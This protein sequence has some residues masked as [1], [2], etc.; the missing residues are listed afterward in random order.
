MKKKITDAGADRE[1]P[2]SKPEEV[3]RP[4]NVVVPDLLSSDEVLSDKFENASDDITPID[5]V[6]LGSR[7]I[8]N[9]DLMRM[10][11]PDYA[12]EIEKPSLEMTSES[13]TEDFEEYIPEEIP[14]PIALQQHDSPSSEQDLY[15]PDIQDYS[16]VRVASSDTVYE[17]RVRKLSWLKPRHVLIPVT[18]IAIVV[19]FLSVI[20]VGHLN[21]RL[22]SP[23]MIHG[24]TVSNPSF[25]FM[26]NFVLMENGVDILDAS[27]KDM[28]KSPGDNGF[29]TNREYFLDMTA[30]EMQ[31]TAI[32]YD[33]AISKGYQIEA[34]HVERAQAYLDWLGTKAQS[35][36]VDLNTYIKGSYG[37]TVTQELIIE[38]LSRRYFAE[39]YA[40]GHK[41]DELKAT[42]EQAEEAYALTPN[43]YDLISYRVLR[44]VFEQKED[45]FIA[46]AHLR[47]Q[48]II[49]G[50]GHDQS[51]F[52]TVAAEY[53]SGAEKDKLLVPDSTLIP[54]VRYNEVDDIEWRVWL[55]DPARQP[56]DCTIFDDEY[57]FPIL[58][59]FSA[60]VRQ[61][62][63]LR[64]IRFFYINRE[65]ATSGTAGVSNPEILPLAQTI[66]DSVTNEISMMNLETTYADDLLS[67]V[68]TSSQSSD[69]F[70]GKYDAAFEEWIF[71]PAR[72]PDD[73]TIIE[74]P[75]QVVILFYVGSSEN[76]EW[77][78]R[79]NSFIRMNNYQAFLLEKQEEYPFKFNAE[80][81]K[82]I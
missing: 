30:K 14:T 29:A 54:E 74:T 32:L 60:R 51:K 8:P 10:I 63:P 66:F 52:E 45:S 59:C 17:P 19:F 50:I 75:T 3:R 49:D 24:E 53:F 78:D 44:I 15:D 68:M 57:G 70:K 31:T 39:D 65:D 48:E 76:P 81:L 55:F 43:Q 21:E 69:T 20:N 26:Y 35:I 16:M 6:P 72:K 36:G 79:V 80:G 18:I 37:D 5:D 58:V 22:A 40:S 56:G 23:L 34:S 28:L 1:T 11:D 47:A 71:D 62:E 61:T 7:S 27:T 42:D 4:G 38:V 33:D 2:Q 25:S 12:P 41:L 73:K 13:K 82:Y 9:D 77:F 46:T 64:N 67:G